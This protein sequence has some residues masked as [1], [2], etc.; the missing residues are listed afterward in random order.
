M[1]S[2][3]SI[4]FKHANC[5][6]NKCVGCDESLGHLPTCLYLDENDGEYEDYDDI[7]VE[8]IQ[9]DE[10]TLPT[11][12]EEI[13]DGHEFDLQHH[14][15]EHD[16]L[17]SYHHVSAAADDSSE[18]TNDDNIPA[19]ITDVVNDGWEHYKQHWKQHN[20]N[21]HDYYCRSHGRSYQNVNRYFP[22]TRCSVCGNYGYGCLDC[23]LA[24]A[25]YQKEKEF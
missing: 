20:T 11:I 8:A 6:Y 21:C 10:D 7:K 9:S 19:I 12:P 23:T 22:T 3:G 4:N 14:V 2:R 17:N 24:E 13:F 25:V 5:D 15:V 1:V 18:V 16:Q